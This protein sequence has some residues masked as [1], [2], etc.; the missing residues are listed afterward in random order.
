MAP[1]TALGL[2]RAAP[3]VHGRVW[4]YTDGAEAVYVDGTVQ[5]IGLRLARDLLPSYVPS[6]AEAARAAQT[7]PAPRANFVKIWVK[8]KTSC[9]TSPIGFAGYSKA[10]QHVFFVRTH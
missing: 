10:S 6:P 5:N 3:L 9:G 7:E 8:A 2:A 1:T 4:A